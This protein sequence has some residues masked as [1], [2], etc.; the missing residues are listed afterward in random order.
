[1]QNK[2]KI[3]AALILLFLIWWLF[4]TPDPVDF[5]ADA[6]GVKLPRGTVE[7][8]EETHGGFHGDGH[9]YIVIRFDEDISDRLTG[10]Y[11]HD[12]PMTENVSTVF[13]GRE[14]DNMVYGAHL[15]H[16][17]PR[18]TN[19]R[20]YFQDRHPE[21]KDPADDSMLFTR[22]SYNYIAAIYDADTR[23]LYYFKFD[24]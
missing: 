18:T 10:A 23:A 22:A 9:T 19:G 5:T 16:S 3:L 2:R 4:R 12:L 21:T 24:T 14:T 6:L 20:Y 15:R 13:Y 11:W 17:L 8:T 7:L 1:M